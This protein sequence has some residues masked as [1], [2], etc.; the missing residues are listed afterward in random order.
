VNDFSFMSWDKEAL[1]TAGLPAIDYFPDGGFEQ[2]GPSGSSAQRRA[3]FRLVAAILRD[4][5]ETMANAK[6]IPPPAGGTGGRHS[7]CCRGGAPGGGCLAWSILR[8][9]WSQPPAT[10]CWWRYGTQRGRQARGRPLAA[11]TRLRIEMTHWR[12][13]TGDTGRY[14]LRDGVPLGEYQ[15][16][17]QGQ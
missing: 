13:A 14:R 10:I 9:T 3:L 1:A 2:V 4:L 16:N 12:L 17:K 11:A 15:T 7:W 6:P 8:A 5:S